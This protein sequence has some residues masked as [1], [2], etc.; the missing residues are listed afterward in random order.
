MKLED[1]AEKHREQPELVLN[2]A[3]KGI[4]QR[5]LQGKSQKLLEDPELIY[6]RNCA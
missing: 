1:K 6:Y 2:G 5:R 4:G 3:K